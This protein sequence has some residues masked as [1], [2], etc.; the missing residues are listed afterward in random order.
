MHM[1]SYTITC[2]HEYIYIHIHVYTY[3]PI[4]LEIWPSLSILHNNKDN[5]IS[6]IKMMSGM[7]MKA[8]NHG[9]Q[10]PVMAIIL[11]AKH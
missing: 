3:V 9:K 4:L 8:I 11:I 10:Q 2:E 1:Q 7:T 5:A 6:M